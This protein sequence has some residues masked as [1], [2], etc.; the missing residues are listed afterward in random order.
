MKKTLA[1]IATLILCS[2]SLA[3]AADAPTKAKEAPKL[4]K[5]MPESAATPAVGACPKMGMMGGGMG[6]MGGGMGMGNAMSPELMKKMQEQMAKIRETSDP[7]ERQKLMQEHFQ[8]MQ[9]AMQAMR[10]NSGGTGCCCPQCA[11]AACAKPAGKGGKCARGM[12]AAAQGGAMGTAPA[13][14]MEQRM[15]MMQMMMENM[16]EHQRQMQPSK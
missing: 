1:L 6:M 2:A 3:M 9:E 11:Q 10:G 5:L 4:D 15:D 8:S 16:L 14:M 7:A 13:N 12:G